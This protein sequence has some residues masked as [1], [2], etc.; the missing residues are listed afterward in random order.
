MKQQGIGWHWVCAVAFVW[1]AGQAALLGAEQAKTQSPVERKGVLAALPSSPGPHMQKIMALGDGEWVNLGKP[2]PDPKWGQGRGRSWSHKMAYAPELQGAFLAGAGPHAYIKPDGH[3]DDIFFYDLNAHKW[4]CIFEGVNTKTFGED[5]KNGLLKVNDDGQL[6]NKD[7]DVV[8]LGARSHSGQTHTYDT[9]SHKWIY[10]GCAPGGIDPDWWSAK[11]EWYLAGAKHLTA[12]GKPDKVLNQPLYFNTITGKFERPAG[13]KPP[14][15][16]GA[17]RGEATFYLPTKKAIWA[18]S[19]DAGMLI[20]NAATGEWT[21]TKKPKGA[22]KGGD[23]GACYDSKRHRIYLSTGGPL[24]ANEGNVY[25]YDVATDTWSNPPNKE[26]A[27]PLPPSNAGVLNYDSVADRVVIFRAAEYVA[28]WDP[29]SH[30]W[31]PKIPMPS[32]FPEVGY[33]SYHGFY[34]PEANAHFIYAACDGADNGAMWVYRFKRA[35]K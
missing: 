19:S 14:R 34:S 22:P 7:G 32:K 20:G 9:D 11:K 5:C 10:N 1:V 25:I 18:Y 6:V 17:G 4:I 23:Y 24:A 26:N 2:A 3:Y 31:T 35:T 21:V 33:P 28:A 27:L 15:G 30:A 8:P 12:Q 13:K 29:D 16:S